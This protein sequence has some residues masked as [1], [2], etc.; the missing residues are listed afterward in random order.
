[1]NKKILYISTLATTGIMALTSLAGTVNAATSLGSYRELVKGISSDRVAPYILKDNKDRLT[2]ADIAKE[3]NVASFNGIKGYNG[4]TVVKTGDTFVADQ[5]DYEVIVYGDVAEKDTNGIKADGRVDSNDANVMLKLAVAKDK[6]T[7]VN[8]TNLEAADIVN[9]GVVDSKDANLALLFAVGKGS[10]DVKLTPEANDSNYTLELKSKYANNVNKANVPVDVKIAKPLSKTEKVVLRVLDSK[11]NVAVAGKEVEIPADMVKKSETVSLAG[12]EDGTYT[13]QLVDKTTEKEVLAKATVV[14][15]TVEPASAKVS[16]NRESWDSAKM[17][18]TNKGESDITKVYY[19]VQNTTDNTKPTFDKEDTKKFDKG[20]TKSV[21]ATNS[22]VTNEIV[23]TELAK[24]AT[25]KVYYVLENS[26][27]SMSDVLDTD[28]LIDTI[29]ESQKAVDAA[30]ITVPDLSKTT[31]FTWEAPEG[32]TVSGYTVVVYKDGK[33]INEKAAATAEY[34]LATEDLAKGAGKYKIEVITKGA[35]LKDSTATMSKEVEVKELAAVTDIKFEIDQLGASI[36]S[37][38]DSNKKEDVKKYEVK[39]YEYDDTEKDYSKTVKAGAV[40]TEDITDTKTTLTI[41]PNKAYKAVVKVIKKTTGNDVV[42]SKATEMEGFYKI[43]PTGKVTKVDVTD[44]TITLTITDDITIKGEKIT[45]Y[46]AKVYTVQ[47]T[48]TEL[49]RHAEQKGITTKYEDG[50]LTI[51]GLNP[52]TQYAYKLLA[53]AN[54]TKGESVIVEKNENN[55]NIV[56]LKKAPTIE[57]KTKIDDVKN[58][59]ANTVYYEG[60]TLK[61]GTAEAIDVSANYSEEFA[62]SLAVIDSLRVGDTITI[63]GDTVELTLTDASTAAGEAIDFAKTVKGKTVIVKGKVFG[64][65]LSIDSDSAAK[66]LRLSGNRARYE[67]GEVHAEKITLDSG[68][69]ASGKNTYTVL[70]GKTATVNGVEVKADKDT[71]IASEVKNNVKLLNVTVRKDETNGLTFTNTIAENVPETEAKIT[72]VADIASIQLGNITIKTT[73]GK[74]TVGQQN[75]DVRGALNVEVNS[76]EVDIS[77]SSLTGNKTVSVSQEEGK[78]KAVITANT[79]IA[80][81]FAIPAGTEI[82]EYTAKELAEKFPTATV[83]QRELIAEYMKQFNL[84]GKGA[85]LYAKG[86]DLTS[87]TKADI[88]ENDKSVMIVFEK[89]TTTTIGGL[90]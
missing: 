72:F 21:Q 42:D 25:Y 76:G 34:D 3:Y 80:A 37:W 43:D 11:G 54:G 18:L 8:N 64:Y 59:T 62:N 50:K 19:V 9:D 65:E 86:T 77:D 14:L 20:T 57:G 40:T 60:T 27:G 17:S 79:K 78:D 75:V 33:I 82:K 47:T 29:T 70:A 69:V 10:I 71:E 15:N 48:N 49:P 87:S 88:A 51:S 32:A 81:P 5:E 84:N 35:N 55:N 16:T 68:V 61:V 2:I 36:L 28:I 58:A 66:E 83:A 7:L 41:D 23:S 85:K 90:K 53:N 56:T 31:S 89:A 12:K 1:M 63:S 24:G 44:N 39:V 45:Q 73:G 46:D 38:K 26:Y 30:K 67:L 52:N 74:V 4:N 6:S 13:I 22:K